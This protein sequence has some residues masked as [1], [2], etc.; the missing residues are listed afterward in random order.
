M[1]RSEEND[2][3]WLIAR[4]SEGVVRDIFQS[5]IEP[6]IPVNHDFIG[7]PAQNDW[8]KLSNKGSVQE[9][10]EKWQDYCIRYA[11]TPVF[12]YSLWWLASLY[13]DTFHLMNRISP[14]EAHILRNFGVEISQA[15]DRLGTAPDYLRSMGL[16]LKSSLLEKKVE[17]YQVSKLHP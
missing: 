3:V 5:I 8:L 11:D 2:S 1:T 12:P 13:R 7:T 17:D 6:I 14:E 16:Y 4:D 9:V 15:L 10:L